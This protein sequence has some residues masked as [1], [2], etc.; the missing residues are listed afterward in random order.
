MINIVLLTMG[1][2]FEKRGKKND[3]CYSVYFS[4]NNGIMLNYFP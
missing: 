3:R 2:I 1:S 4:R